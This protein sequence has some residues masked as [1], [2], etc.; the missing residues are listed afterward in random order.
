MLYP[1]LQYKS[2]HPLGGTEG[3]HCR[4]CLLLSALQT[5][6]AWLSCQ[7]VTPAQPGWQTKT[8]NLSAA[9]LSHNLLLAPRVY[10][11]HIKHVHV[12]ARTH[13]HEHTHTGQKSQWK[14]GTCSLIFTKSAPQLALSVF[15][16][17]CWDWRIAGGHKGKT[18][19]PASA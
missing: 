4:H 1:Q 7:T 11:A 9:I 12:R 6:L 5:H 16:Y 14:S 2:H 13:T 15:C 10:Q 19:F 3:W 8:T 17:Q 18:S